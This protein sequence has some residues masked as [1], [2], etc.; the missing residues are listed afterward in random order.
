MSYRVDCV[1]L[2]LS[3]VENVGVAVWIASTSLSIQKLAYFY[4]KFR[5]RHFGFPM[6]DDV[7]SLTTE[8]GMVKYVAIT[9]GT[10]SPAL[11]VQTLFLLLFSTCRFWSVLPPF[12]YFRSAETRGD[13]DI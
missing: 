3:M 1:I 4:I 7:G 10:A 12:R 13:E 9:A 6:S 5:G 8:T 2:K 11:P